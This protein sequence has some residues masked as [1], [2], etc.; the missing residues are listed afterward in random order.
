MRCAAGLRTPGWA[1]QLVEVMLDLLQKAKMLEQP[2][3]QVM[4][5][6]LDARSTPQAQTVRRITCKESA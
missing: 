2:Q 1:E 3:R 4:L 6:C 5:L